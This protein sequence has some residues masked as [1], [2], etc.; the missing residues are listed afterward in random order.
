MNYVLGEG[1][2]GRGR[3]GGRRIEKETEKETA[4]KAAHCVLSLASLA[5]LV[6]RISIEH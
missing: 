6:M 1:V 3:L 4:N 2:K 5:V